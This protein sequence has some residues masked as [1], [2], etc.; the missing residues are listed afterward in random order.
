MLLY[1]DDAFAQHDTGNHPESLHRITRLNALLRASDLL[2]RA[3]CPVWQAASI[4]RVSAVHSADYLQQL[5]QWCVQSAGRIEADTVVSSGSWLAALRG[6]GAAMDAVQRIVAGEHQTAF[7]AIRPPGHHAL[8]TGA[9][10]FC[11]LNN[12]AIAAQSALDQGL[13]RVLIVDWDVHHGNGTQDAFYE[14]D[15]VGFFSIHRSP[16]YPG[17]GAKN[18][19]GSGVGLGWTLNEPVEANVTTR[20]FFDRFTRGLEDIAKRVQPQLILLSAGFD[21]HRLDP[22]GSL[23]LEEED[24]GPLTKIVRD[25]ASSFCAGKVVSLL[26]GGYHLQHMPNSVLQHVAA[27]E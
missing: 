19:T 20:A 8:P 7:C 3:S 23:C 17:T 13:D 26:E 14:N 1:L 25:V 27:L 24:F 11:L 5:Q 15:R 10:G 16:F 9:M 18:E 6:A 4:E 12:I 2:Q 21:A 22:V